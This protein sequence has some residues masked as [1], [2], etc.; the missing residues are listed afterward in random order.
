MFSGPFIIW[1]S[2]SE[3][4]VR[5]DFCGPDGSPLVSFLGDPSGALFYYPDRS[6]AFFSPGGIPLDTG[7]LT[8]NALISL[9]R[10]GFPAEPV[11]WELTETCDTL[12]TSLSWRFTSDGT[13]SLSV[14]LHGGSLFPVVSTGD[15]RLEATATSWHDQFNAWPLEWL[16]SSPSLQVVLRIRSIDTDTP[17]VQGAWELTVPVPVDTILPPPGEWTL[18]VALPIR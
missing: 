14:V 10:T 9:I 2:R 15:T 11:H 16:L 1:A 4:A 18:A 12:G 3:G 5:A 6:E 8:V 17:P 13:D 7:Y